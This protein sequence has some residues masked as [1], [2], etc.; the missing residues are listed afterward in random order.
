MMNLERPQKKQKKK[1]TLCP[2][3]KKLKNR[4]RQAGPAA[5]RQVWPLRAHQEGD[6]SRA[7]RHGQLAS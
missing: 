1:L 6:E 4:L 5:R 3:E 7:D 2:F